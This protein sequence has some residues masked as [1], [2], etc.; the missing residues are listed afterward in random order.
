MGKNLLLLLIAFLATG[1]AFT[2]TA[3]IDFSQTPPNLDTLIPKIAA[4]KNDSARFYLALS[5]LTISETNPV[6]D[7]LNSEKILVYGQKYNDPVCQLLGLACLGYDYRE[8]GNQVK[9]LDY[10]IQANKVA[11]KSKNNRLISFAK[12]MLALNYLDLGDYSKAVSYNKAA[13]EA[14]STY[15]PDILT[16]VFYLDMG[17]IYFTMGKVDSALTYTQ[18]AYE[19]GFKSGINYWLAY[20]YLQFGSIHAEMKN[21]TLALSYW[22]LALDEASRINSPKFASTTYAEIA[23]YYYDNKQNDS[24][25]LYA[26]KAISVVQHTAFSTMSIVPSRLLL[27]I[28]RDNNIDSAFK[29]SEIYRIANDSLFNMKAIQQTQLMTFEEDARQ[30]E[31]TVQQYRADETRKHNLQ[32]TLIALGIVSFIILF[33]LLSRRLITNSKVIEFLGV[34]ALLIV[35]EFFNL[36]LHPFL[37]DV[38]NHSPLLML[39][40][41]VLIAALLVPLH[42]R[43]EKWATAKLVEKN[44]QIRLAA[45]KRTIERLDTRSEKI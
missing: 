43:L 34:I 42:H 8:F 4:E 36:L 15:E 29:Y 26:R 18:K 1:S 17:T 35:F 27:D 13:I 21:P 41:L 22:K 31:L 7:M 40:G 12:A 5:A 25:V 38:T 16:V 6:Q 20:N 39:F 11:E 45:A 37:E 23:N 28:Y 33:L 32:Y 2:Q 14:A 44:K 19:T 24:A 30:Q 10:N 9:S 3:R